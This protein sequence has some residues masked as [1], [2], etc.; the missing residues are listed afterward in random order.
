MFSNYRFV[1]PRNQKTVRISRISYLFAG[2]LGPAYVLFK[3]GPRQLLQSLGWSIGC[4]L[5]TFAFVVKGLPYIPGSFQIIV[6]IVG[7]PAVFLLHAE[8]TVGLVRRSLLQRRWT[9][10]PVY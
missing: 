9:S 6:L 10:R 2:F 1:D 4:A 7:I 5:G 3:S 8:K